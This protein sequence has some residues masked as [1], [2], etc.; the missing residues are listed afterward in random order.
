MCNGPLD[1]WI[2][3]KIPKQP[4]LDWQTKMTVIPN[5]AKGL[6]YLH[7]EC[8]QRIVHLDIKPQ[9]ILL[10][11]NLSAMISYFGLSKLID[12]DQ[13]QVVTTMRGTSSYLALELF[14]SIVTEKADVYSFG[15]VVIEVFCGR[16]NLDRL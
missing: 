11:V 9:N 2:F 1:T 7:E 16:K 12:K 8:R 15:I 14:S 4:A 10:D 6:A 5:I 13:S 3:H